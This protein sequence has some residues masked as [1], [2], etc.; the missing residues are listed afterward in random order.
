MNA[1]ANASAAPIREEYSDAEKLRLIQAVWLT[2]MPMKAAFLMI[3]QVAF[4]GLS[5]GKGGRPC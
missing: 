4:A 3:G 1:I 2:G 5:L